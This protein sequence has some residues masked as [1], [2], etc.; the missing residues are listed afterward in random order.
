MI[1]QPYS[2]PQVTVLAKKPV[3]PSPAGADDKDD[4]H[5]SDR[6]IMVQ[7]PP[8]PAG[9]DGSGGTPAA[10]PFP[11]RPP[12]P[13]PPPPSPP[14]PPQ[15]LVPAQFPILCVK[16]PNDSKIA[17]KR[18]SPRGRTHLLWKEFPYVR[19]SNVVIDGQRSKNGL[20]DQNGQ[21]KWIVQGGELINY[22]ISVC[23][24]FWH[25]KRWLTI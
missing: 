9:H 3:D 18:D 6:E 22:G 23:S 7:F 11:P 17:K 12:P 19:N 2:V 13:P 8:W 1:R 14:P 15:Y 10:P 20:H 5:D 21:K 16:T 24:W 4:G 25:C